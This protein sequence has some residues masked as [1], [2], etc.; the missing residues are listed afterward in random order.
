M[1][2]IWNFSISNITCLFS[3]W[4]Y[5]RL[6]SFIRATLFVIMLF[7]FGHLGHIGVQLRPTGGLKLINFLFLIP[8]MNSLCLNYPI[9]KVTLKPGKLKVVSEIPSILLYRIV[10]GDF[11]PCRLWHH[12][13]LEV[14]LSQKQKICFTVWFF[15]LLSF[16]MLKNI[17]FFIFRISLFLFFIFRVNLL[18]DSSQANESKDSFWLRCFT[19]IS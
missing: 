17:L 18:L 1:V 15:C 8:S 6:Q 7:R 5:G 16:L 11:E 4:K 14:D 13:K 10:Y 9:W 19:I 2:K 12:Q 3:I